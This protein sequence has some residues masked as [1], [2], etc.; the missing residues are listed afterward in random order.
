MSADTIEPGDIADTIKAAR[1][2]ETETHRI[3]TDGT[4]AEFRAWRKM[5]FGIEMEFDVRIEDADNDEIVPSDFDNSLIV[6]ASPDAVEGDDVGTHLHEAVDAS[7]YETIVRG[8]A[9][10]FETEDAY[11]R[12]HLEEIAFCSEVYQS[13]PEGGVATFFTYVGDQWDTTRQYL[14]ATIHDTIEN[15][16]YD[17]VSIRGNAVMIRK[18]DSDDTDD[19]ERLSL[20]GTQG[21]GSA[22]YVILDAPDDG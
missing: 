8:I 5:M 20:K 16:L 7:L 22:R 2:G 10:G 21:L 14:G 17:V 13:S 18:Q 15:V 1:N 9:R 3:R 6:R 12:E 4:I 19:T 11:I